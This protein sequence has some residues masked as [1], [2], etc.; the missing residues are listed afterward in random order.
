MNMHMFDGAI[1]LLEHFHVHITTDN[2]YE[3]RSEA[4]LPGISK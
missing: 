4:I 2:L 3:F 1:I